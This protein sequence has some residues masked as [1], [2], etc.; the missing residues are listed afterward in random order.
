LN[1]RVLCILALTILP[2]EGPVI[3]PTTDLL[4]P[5]LRS[6]ANRRTGPAPGLRQIWRYTPA[7][8]F[9]WCRPRWSLC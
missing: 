2:A 4:Q 7:S 5:I 9:I 8:G 3:D 6:P 1:K